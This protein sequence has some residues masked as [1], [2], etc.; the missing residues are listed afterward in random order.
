MSS[1][2]SHWH[3]S[4]VKDVM[5]SVSKPLLEFRQNLLTLNSHDIITIMSKH[6]VKKICR[7]SKIMKIY[8]IVDLSLSFDKFISIFSN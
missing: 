8:W 3:F 1:S 2:D 7:L 6:N 5:K 4:Q